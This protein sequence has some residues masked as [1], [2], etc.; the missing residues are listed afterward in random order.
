M[1]GGTSHLASSWPHTTASRRPRPWPPYSFGQV[2]TAQPSSNFFACHAFERWITSALSRSPIGFG[3]VSPGARYR[4]FFSSHAR[5][6]ARN[7]A[8]CGVSSKF[9]GGLL[10][11]ARVEVT[12]RRLRFE[13]LDQ[14]LAPQARRA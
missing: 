14:L 6:L 12:A 10:S 1:F 8:S 3:A 5:A 2:S 11:L 7:A 4:A 9:I 13:A